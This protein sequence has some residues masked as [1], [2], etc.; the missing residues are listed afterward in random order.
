M[1]MNV[2]LTPYLM[3]SG[4]CREAMEF[5]RDVFGGELQL[6]TYGE[7]DPSASGDMKDRIMHSSLMGGRADLM[8]GDSPEAASFGE[9]RVQL[10][11]SGSDEGTLRN[12]FEALSAGGKVE[13]PLEKQMWGD[14][15]GSL[16]DRYGV[17]WMVNIN[18][19][20]G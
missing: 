3:F 2:D 15:F 17:D 18:V 13:V 14:F 8:A 10:A 9:G 11:L 5:Y 1:S 6:Q 7:V 12:L 4:Q 16:K 20:R 19:S